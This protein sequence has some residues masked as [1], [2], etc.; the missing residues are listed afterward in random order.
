MINSRERTGAAE[1]EEGSD[2]FVPAIFLSTHDFPR[3]LRSG[4]ALTDKLGLVYGAANPIPT[5][6]RFELGSVRETA[7]ERNRA[8]H[9]LVECNA[10]G[11]IRE[12]H[13][14]PVERLC[15]Q[16]SELF[17]AVLRRKLCCA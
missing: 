2:C 8:H 16:L 1:R 17:A 5:T 12:L 3:L 4:T 9:Y 10:R 6:I 14:R 13:D 15:G 7:Y 11:S